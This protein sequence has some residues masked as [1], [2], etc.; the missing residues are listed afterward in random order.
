VA[1]QSLVQPQVKLS[2]TVSIGVAEW[3]PGSDDVA[4]LLLRADAALYRAKQDGRNCVRVA[5]ESP[6]ALSA[7]QSP[8]AV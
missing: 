3:R 5:E 2:L 4:R 1:S 6:A 8:D 7:A